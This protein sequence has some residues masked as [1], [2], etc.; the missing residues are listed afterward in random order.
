MEAVR[1]TCVRFSPTGQEWACATPDGVLLYAL[2]DVTAFA[3]TD[4]D[5]DVTPAAVTA[6]LHRREWAKALLMTL[7]LGI[8]MYDLIL[9]CV[10]IR[11]SINHCYT[12]KCYVCYKQAV[13]TLLRT[14][15][16]VK[17]AFRSLMRM[18]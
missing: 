5:E 14:V 13:R 1:T 8:H 17:H 7:H 11:C 18:L 16:Y 3:P 6:A 12:S 10:C 2:D 4:L 9:V 15:L